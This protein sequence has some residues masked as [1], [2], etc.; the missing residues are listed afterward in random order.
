MRGE[1]DEEEDR[2]QE[3][4]E[5]E[6]EERLLSRVL[7]AMRLIMMAGQETSWTNADSGCPLLVGNQGRGWMAGEDR[8]RRRRCERGGGRGRAV[9]GE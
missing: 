3:E 6:E 2:E 4:E 7:G 5:E 8:T 1:E 9:E